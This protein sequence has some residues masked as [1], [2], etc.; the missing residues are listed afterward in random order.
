MYFN[1]SQKI[2]NRSGSSQQNVE[3]SHK[4]NMEDTQ[5]RVVHRDKWPIPYSYES[6]SSLTPMAI[7]HLNFG[8]SYPNLQVESAPTFYDLVENNCHYEMVDVKDPVFV[9]DFL[10]A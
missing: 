6:P 2:K 4:S 9:C 1:Q 5:S 7:S 10:A 3:L 8:S